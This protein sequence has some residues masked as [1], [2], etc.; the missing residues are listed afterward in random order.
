MTVPLS[1]NHREN[2]L[3]HVYN[4]TKI[5]LLVCNGVVFIHKSINNIAVTNLIQML[6]L[7]F[8]LTAFHHQ[9]QHETAR[10]KMSLLVYNIKI[11]Q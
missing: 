11:V 3:R 8:I 4:N 10:V 1:F 7:F 6:H 2:K 9:A 5:R